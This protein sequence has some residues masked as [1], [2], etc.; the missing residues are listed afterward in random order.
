MASILVVDDRPLNRELL[1]T[2]LQYHGHQISEANEGE[3]ALQL[4]QAQPPDLIIT[5]IQM[6]GMN[7]FDLVHR[8]RA[9]AGLT[10]SRVI[11]Y[12]AS[13]KTREALELARECR[14][15]H[16]LFKPCE[17][18][19][20]LKVVNEA[21]R[22]V[23]QPAPAESPSQQQLAQLSN[24]S[25]RLTALTEACLDLATELDPGQLLDK[26]CHSARELVKAQIAV[27]VMPD[28]HLYVSPDAGVL[29]D[30]ASGP[31]VAWMQQLFAAGEQIWLRPEDEIPPR[32]DG[33]PVRNLQGVTLR[34]REGSF[35]WLCCFDRLQQ[36]RFDEQDRHA[37]TTLAV[38]V[39]QIYAN[40]RLYAL[41][42]QQTQELLLQNQ[43]LAEMQANLNE[44]QERLQLAL[45]SA[46]L[47]TWDRNL[48]SGYL[49]WDERL[50]EIYGF[51]PDEF[52]HDYRDWQNRVHPDDYA[53]MMQ[54]AFDDPQQ[55]VF[56]NEHR[57]LLPDGSTRYVSSSGRVLFDDQNQPCRIVGVGMDI[58]ARKLAEQQLRA[59]EQLLQNLSR[60]V[61]GMLYQYHRFADGRSVMPFVSEGARRIFGLAPEQIRADASLLLKFIH[62]EDLDALQR[63]IQRT[64]QELVPLQS[65]YRVCVPG[66]PEKWVYGEA[67]PER[68]EDGS[69]LLHGYIADVTQQ[70]RL[71]TS[72]IASEERLQL[73]TAAGQIGIWDLDLGSG[74][75]IWNDVMHRLYD[76][77]ADDQEL[78]TEDWLPRLHADDR[79]QA[80]EEF[81]NALHHQS[82]YFSAFRVCHRDGS[83]HYLEG[84]AT[85]LR[86]AQGQAYRVLGYKI[87]VTRRREM[88][89]SLRTS[90]ERLRLTKSIAGFGIWERDLLSEF[91][92]FDERMYE[93]Y[94]LDAD[95]PDPFAAALAKIHPDDRARSQQVMQEAIQS[96]Q[97]VSMAARILLDGKTRYIEG[98]AQVFANAEGQPQ[99][100]LGLMQDI[101]DRKQTEQALYKSQ[102]RMRLAQE[103]MGLGVWERDMQKGLVYIDARLNQLLGLDPPRDSIPFDELVEHIYPDDRPGWISA[104]WN[105]AEGRAQGAIPYRVRRADGEIRHLEG[106]GRLFEMPDGGPP[107][108]IGSTRDVTEQVR[109]QDALRES[110]ERLR[111]AKEASGMGVWEIDLASGQIVR[112][113]QMCLLLGLRA[114]IDNRDSLAGLERLHPEDRQ[115]LGQWLRAGMEGQSREPYVFRV[116]QE[117]G[118][119]EYLESHSQLFFKSDGSG[120]R[121]IGSTRD[122][123]ERVLAAEQLTA[124]QARLLESHL[125]LENTIVE[126][127]EMAARAE[128]ASHAKSEFLTNMSHELRTPLNGV[129][130]MVQLLR[131][132]ELDPEQHGFAEIIEQSGKSLL[133][134]IDKILHFSQLEAA[135]LQ[136]VHE[137]FEPRALIARVAETFAPLLRQKHLLLKQNLD[138]GLPERLLGDAGRLDQILANL[139]D[140]AIKFTAVG[141]IELSIHVEAVQADRLQL[142]FGVQDTGVGISEADL[143]R[144]FE[145]F[146]QADGSLTRRYG[147]TGIGLSI[148]HRLVRCLGGELGCSS[149]LNQGSRFSF[150]LSLARD[151]SAPAATAP[152]PAPLAPLAVQAQVLL[153]EDNPINQVVT[154]ALLEK[155]GCRVTVAEDGREA[156]EKLTAQSVDLVLMDCQMPVMDGYEA[157]RRIRAGEAGVP[158]LPIVA[159]TAHALAED[160]QKCL[161]AGM[162]DYLAKPFGSEELLNMLGKWLPAESRSQQKARDS[163]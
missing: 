4:A 57:V 114:G 141:E 146:T 17:P 1:R 26:V 73:A 90:E 76:L 132:T 9:T 96:L 137:T 107:R 123:T 77:P 111:L 67:V 24:T 91:T 160:R 37:L 125:Q 47:G 109:I 56:T 100:M 135:D 113:D 7:G 5:D 117:D 98:C 49:Y 21:L 64:L 119:W 15:E 106:Y 94:E 112:D 16:V 130:G 54:P 70:R 42:Q 157:T 6:P 122:V 58:T 38:H 133:N 34:A 30:S 118:G 162:D 150:S 116:R 50:L 62:A 61:P 134:V 32:P 11:F 13:Y 142:R 65:A 55:P 161:D 153:V 101:T 23:P 104:I 8:L 110:E 52:S 155:L 40:A 45:D 145:P 152:E 74:R 115:A 29:A 75:L 95:C 43:Q 121:V 129:L 88:T 2:L 99:R 53:E 92:L 12:T 63:A 89:M 102:E 105:L 103:A 148:A 3:E 120:A 156:I 131:L 154:A 149:V 87:D 69:V 35:G 22:T 25:L 27:L 80:A 39:G 81:K 44:N 158:Q 14:V 159:V 51:R 68:R 78:R 31:W 93:L 144:I 86:D 147:G 127:R 41:L 138:P 128:A 83:I 140:N 136:L 143:A 28:G 19:E 20:I 72:L 33:R 46:R 84:Q 71:E 48:R 10:D 124:S 18:D 163:R 126:L 36:G 60:Q 85:V 108:L 97:P 59:S 82:S 79:A 66:E 139:V 151:D